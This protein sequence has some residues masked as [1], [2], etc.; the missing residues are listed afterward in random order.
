MSPR[1]GDVAV[2]NERTRLAWQRTV[3]AGLACALVLVRLL[4]D[5]SAG[6]AALVGL[7]ALLSAALLGR[8][9]LRRYV[10]NRAA[11]HAGRPLADARPQLAITLLTAV[12]GLGGLTYITLT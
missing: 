8:W 6:A 10:A 7:A 9:T 4:V 5:I 3:L 1:L 2:Q 11:L 12:L